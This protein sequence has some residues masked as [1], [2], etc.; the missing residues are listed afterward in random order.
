MTASNTASNN[1]TSLLVSSQVPDFVADEHPQ[2]VTFLEKYYEFLEQK[3][4]LLDTTKRF[5]QN[6]NIDLADPKFQDKIYN[7]FLKLL[8][9][10]VVAD[11]TVLIK[12]IKDFYRA[13]G[14]ENAVRFLARILFSKE[15]EFY[16]P[17][18]D[19]LRASDGKWFVE[20]SLRVTD[21]AVNNV[22]NSIALMN[23]KN[24]T[25]RGAYSNATAKV[26]TIDVYYDKGDFVAELKISGIRR[27]FQSQ[28]PIFCYYTEEGI[29]K[30]LS[31]NI[32]SGIITSVKVQKSGTGYIAGTSVPV[33]SDS[34]R[35]ADI[36]INRVTAGSL[37]DI[38]VTYGGAGYIEGD[39][40][41]VT[42]PYGGGGIG[43]S[44]Q[45]VAVDLT[46]RYHPNTYNFV[47]T[48][49]SQEENTILSNVVFS[50]LNSSNIYTTIANAMQ[51]WTYANTGPIL[52]AGVTA[53][54][55]GY[56]LLPTLSVRGNTYIR[57][58]GVIGRVGVVSGGL[59]YSIG[60][61]IEFV[62]PLGGYGTGAHAEVSNVAANGAITEVKITAIPGHTAGGSGYSRIK[63]PIPV[64]NSVT[65][66]GAE[67]VTSAFLASD[68]Q[69]KPITDDIGAIQELIIIS[70]GTNYLTPPLLDLSG[71]GDGTALANATIARVLYVYPGR[72]I[73]DDG[74]LSAYNFIQDRDYYQN[75]SYVIKIDE[76]LN[77]YRTALNNL[78]HPLGM[79]LFGEYTFIND[80]V[81]NK[82]IEV[83]NTATTFFHEGNYQII[84]KFGS[85]NVNSINVSYTP[86]SFASTYTANNQYR[87]DSYYANGRNVTVYSPSHK[88]SNSDY[89]YVSFTSNATIHLVDGLYVVNSANNNYFEFAIPNVTNTAF[90]SSISYDPRITMQAPPN[91]TFT[92]LTVGQNVYVV[93]DAVDPY[94][95]EQKYT[96]V[97]ANSTQF[98]VIDEDIS[99]VFDETGNCN[100][101][102]SHVYINTSNKW[103]S[104]NDKAYITFFDGDTANTVNGYSVVRGANANTI[105]LSFADPLFASGNASIINKDITVTSAN[106]A[107]YDNANVQIWFNSGDLANVVNTVYKV[108][109]I[110]SNTFNITVDQITTVG[111]DLT[112]YCNN[113]VFNITQKDHGYFDG[114]RI[115][116]EYMSG[117]L[118]SIANGI[119][120]VEN[121]SDVDT[122]SIYRTDLNITKANGVGS[123]TP[124]ANTFRVSTA[125]YQT[126]G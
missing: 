71:H 81:I 49:I 68:D 124:S 102:T 114:D 77:K 9:V 12:Y 91:T 60:D 28:E 83:T 117:D 96:V 108:D 37:K 111:G 59:N 90:G 62:N 47:G 67:L 112:M 26:E 43:A 17:K 30:R 40:V 3:G 4:E 33:I 31:A 107:Q 1:K 57:S 53:S 54:G 61:S 42:T 119:F 39:A 29:D 44:G 97:S 101:W 118:K 13:K 20:R 100:V 123:L 116:M 95:T 48:T 45:V 87:N 56:N 7:Q 11:K 84:Y 21:V 46:E 6:M 22:A 76:S 110:D 105:V 55:Q 85:Y 25:I 66:Y 75:Y 113:I 89:V 19:I 93:F 64:A 18:K 125:L 121:V 106:N 78:T 41:L 23:F 104:A 10:N 2:F 65:G 74:K 70:G 109:Y 98:T 103:F 5:T 69:L 24:H 38:G 80:V 115:Y 14:T 73:N 92:R 32:Y 94:L 34:G 72:Y 79:K 52:T 99:N 88:F 120:K 8:S 63:K 122:F 35:N 51:Y 86:L 82:E 126:V 16:Y 36:K 27:E 15:I 58:L 50:N